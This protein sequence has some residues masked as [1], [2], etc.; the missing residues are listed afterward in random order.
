MALLLIPE[1][2]GLTDPKESEVFGLSSS[3]SGPSWYRQW[4][5]F[6]N[7]ALTLSVVSFSNSS[8]AHESEESVVRSYR[9]DHEKL[10]HLPDLKKR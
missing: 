8:S 3:S 7:K 4:S 1:R 9:L 5:I 2:L 10:D 6:S